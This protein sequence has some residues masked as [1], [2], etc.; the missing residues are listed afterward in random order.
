M[1]TV[2]IQQVKSS[3]NFVLSNSAINFFSDCGVLLLP[4]SWCK[5]YLALWPA[6]KKRE[7]LSHFQRLNVSLK[8]KL[9]MNETIVVL[10]TLV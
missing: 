10:I 2:V 5:Y 6:R 7:N 4:T 9:F 1:L 8:D 3:G